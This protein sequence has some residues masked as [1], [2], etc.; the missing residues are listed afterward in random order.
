[1]DR[2]QAIQDIL[3]MINLQLDFIASLLERFRNTFNFTVPYL[4]YLAIV[5]L[6]IVA[7]LLYLVPVRWI[8]MVWG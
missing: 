1:M 4:S 7:T 3:Q 6:C 8:I 5:V 2:F